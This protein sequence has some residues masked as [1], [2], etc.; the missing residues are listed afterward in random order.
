MILQDRPLRWRAARCV[1][2]RSRMYRRRQGEDQ[3]PFE[4]NVV[5][6][7]NKHPVRGNARQSPVP[8]AGAGH[9]TYSMEAAGLPGSVLAGRT[10]LC[11]RSGG[12]NA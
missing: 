12:V 5:S 11:G 6:V 7:L 9:Y 2:V 3:V 1:W 4:G 8:E 10:G